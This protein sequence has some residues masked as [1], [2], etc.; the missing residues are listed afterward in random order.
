[1]YSVQIFERIFNSSKR[2]KRRLKILSSERM[3]RHFS[4]VLDAIQQI[5]SVFSSR[6]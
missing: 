3:A 1:M 2:S 5:S 6:S 4:A